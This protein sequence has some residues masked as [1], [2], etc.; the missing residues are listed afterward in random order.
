ML[1]PDIDND[2]LVFQ[3]EVHFDIEGAPTMNFKTMQLDPFSKFHYDVKMYQKTTGEQYYLFSAFDDCTIYI[4]NCNK[5][6]YDFLSKLIPISDDI[7]IFDYDEKAKGR[8]T[9]FVGIP[10]EYRYKDAPSGMAI[11]FTD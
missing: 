1:R 8:P 11:I 9:E 4:M 6:V 5:D 10:E 7:T 2:V 3:K